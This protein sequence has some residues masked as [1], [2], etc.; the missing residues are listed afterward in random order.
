MVLRS[1]GWITEGFELPTDGMRENETKNPTTLVVKS[2]IRG[3]SCNVA[4]SQMQSWQEHSL[5]RLSAGG[6]DAGRSQSW[7]QQQHSG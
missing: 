3:A 7:S 5:P 4:P 6:S 2:G 1:C